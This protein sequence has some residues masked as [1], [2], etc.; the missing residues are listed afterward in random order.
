[1]NALSK[2]AKSGLVCLLALLLLLPGNLSTAAEE[3]TG[4]SGEWDNISWELNCRTGELIVRGEG[5]MPSLKNLP[6]EIVYDQIPWYEFRSYIKKVIIED[7]ITEVI[8]SAFRECD[9]LTE[10]YIGADVCKINAYAFAESV[11]IE[12]IVVSPQ[13]DHFLSENNVLFTKDKTKLVKFPAKI[14]TYSIPSTVTTVGEGAFW[15]CT[16]LTD[17]T[18]PNRLDTIEGSAFRQCTG[19]KEITFPSSL[20]TIREYSFENCD[21]LTE[22][23]IPDNVTK[24]YDFAF[25]HCNNIR[26]LYI[27]QGITCIPAYAFYGLTGITH[28]TLPRNLVEIDSQ[29]F[30]ACTALKSVVIFNKL[31]T[32]HIPFVD[33]D[34]ITDIYLVGTEAD[35][36]NLSIRADRFYGLYNLHYGISGTLPNGI[37][38]DLKSD[39]G[40]MILT[41]KGSLTGDESIWK[42][43]EELIT[44]VYVSEGIT[45]IQ[46]CIDSRYKHCGSETKDGHTYQ[47][48]ARPCIITYD[49]NGGEGAPPAQIKQFG[50][51]HVIL[52]EDVDQ[53]H[54]ACTGWSLDKF[55]IFPSYNGGDVLD[56]HV[57]TVLYAV[58][59]PFTGTDIE[60]HSLPDKTV[61]TLGEKL[62]MTGAVLR[63]NRSN[64]A[65][66][67]ETQGLV[68]SGYDAYKLGRQKITVKFGP[69]KTH[70]YVTVVAKESDSVLTEIQPIVTKTE[71]LMGEE[72]DL[73][74]LSLKLTFSDG[75]EQIVTEGFTLKGFSSDAAGDVTVTVDYREHST[76]F[77]VTVKEAPPSDDPPQEE[78]STESDESTAESIENA[79]SITE[80]EESIEESEETDE[81]GAP[82]AAES[83]N[84]LPGASSTPTASAESAAS[85]DQD[86]SAGRSS[87]W[88]I[89]LALVIVTIGGILLI[90]RRRK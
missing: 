59:T 46:N 88:W 70:F 83:K 27:G 63:V 85:T 82:S 41:G 69:E 22:L 1:M 32:I 80:S 8:E 48:Y 38:W 30:G 37:Q 71:Y 55:A 9:A 73:S 24:L 67:L 10:V 87:A 65:Y 11:H 66:Y 13:N 21:G 84:P 40:S 90:L 19:L 44:N 26:E 2:I 6:I 64:G 28:L 16:E 89:V 50:E 72:F 45:G 43:Y 4:A 34:N 5:K 29:G 78:E 76:Q 62:D 39:Q 17:I 75:S 61:Y 25:A 86:A 33:C 74:T 49:G 42:D 3:M 81:E 68:V 57:D 18:F 56:K 52:A 23:I 79:E 31:G 60:M 53:K 47:I 20:T 12:K 58:W 7:G 51:D 77:L 54:Y 36:H 35:T 14:E 15:N